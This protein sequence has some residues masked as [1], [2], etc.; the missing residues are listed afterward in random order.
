[1]V[2]A[3]EVGGVTSQMSLELYC[4]G[5]GIKS[6]YRV[7]PAVTWLLVRYDTGVPDPCASLGGA[8]RGGCG[9]VGGSS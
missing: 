7:T 6:C 3:P 5:A 1:M 9:A 2:N 8:A 4:L